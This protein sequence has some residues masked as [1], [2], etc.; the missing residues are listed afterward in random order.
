V[1][2][3][4]LTL[5]HLPAYL[6]IYSYLLLLVMLLTCLLAQGLSTPGAAPVTVLDLRNN[7]IG[8]EGGKAIAEALRINKVILTMTLTLTLTLILT[9]A[10]V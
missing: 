10:L 1:R 5:T 4:L 6:L 7:S 3:H 8:S 2:T 9:L